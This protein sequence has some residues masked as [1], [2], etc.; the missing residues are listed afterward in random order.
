MIFSYFAATS[1]SYFDCVSDSDSVC[2]VQVL[3]VVDE[4]ANQ[5]R[6]VHVALGAHPQ[7]PVDVLPICDDTAV[8]TTLAPTFITFQT[9]QI[10]AIN[11]EDT[12]LHDLPI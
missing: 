7:L 5:N 6:L 4:L 8:L 10:I 1:A 11:N 3:R 12:I 9:V 2:G